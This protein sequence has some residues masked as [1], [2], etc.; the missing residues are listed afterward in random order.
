MTAR[1]D[2]YNEERYNQKLY[3]LY[4][5][6]HYDPLYWDAAVPGLPR[7]TIFQASET[8]EFFVY[9]LRNHNSTY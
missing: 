6:I 1:V 7:Q 9:K 5:G 3:L 4:N 2:K 8:G